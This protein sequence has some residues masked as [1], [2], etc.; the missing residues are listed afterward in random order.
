MIQICQWILFFLQPTGHNHAPNH[1]HIAAIELNN[2][3]KAQATTSDEQTS[4]ILHSTL[5]VFLLNTPSERPR[6]EIIMQTIHR[7]CQ[8]STATSTNSLPDDFRKSDCGE[9]F[10]I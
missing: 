7:Q 9:D 10:P 4:T 2:R 3:I 6:T 5:R 1:E 8:A